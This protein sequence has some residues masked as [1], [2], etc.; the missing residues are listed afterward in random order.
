M[1]ILILLHE[2][3]RD[4]NFNIYAITHLA[5]HWVDDGHSVGFQIGCDGPAPPADIIIIHVDLSVVDEKYIKFAEQYPIVI[6]NKANDIRKTTISHN[7]ISKG[8][9]YDGSV[10]IKSDCNYAGMPERRLSPEKYSGGNEKLLFSSPHDY[11]VYQS[12]NEVPDYYFNDYFVCEKFLP[13]RTENGYATRHFV[14]L[15]DKATWYRSCSTQPIIRGSSW[16]KVETISPD[17]AIIERREAL[18]FD[19]GKFDYVIHEGKAIL[20]DANKTVGAPPHFPGI[21]EIFRE[22]SKGL[23]SFFK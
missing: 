20:L 4:V 10:I 8:S 12:I 19:Y 17:P 2:N 1:R 22:R 15:G 21:D 9:S 18:G 13:E 7:L 16:D 3:S 14:F 6:N 23:Y 11:K 5:N